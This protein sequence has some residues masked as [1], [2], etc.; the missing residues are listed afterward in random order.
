M[1]C[2]CV[3]APAGQGHGVSRPERWPCPGPGARL[4]DERT[5]RPGG[6]AGRGIGGPGLRMDRR[7]LQT[8]SGE[9]HTIMSKLI[10]Y[11][12]SFAF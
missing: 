9:T 7:K 12:P 10:H 3:R 11:I 6:S 8:G 5:G 4:G 1:S 2:T